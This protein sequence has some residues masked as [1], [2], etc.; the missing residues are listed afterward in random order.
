MPHW[1]IS[2][3][4]AGEPVEWGGR[5]LMPFAY[6]LGVRLPLQNW[7]G[8][9]WTWTRPVSVLVREADGQEKVLPVTNITRR[10]TWTL[11]GA[12]AVIV[13]A[14][15]ILNVINRDKWRKLSHG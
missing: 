14:A 11:Y 1:W 8:A 15:G 12:C 6:T 2:E 10:V 9:Q 5:M 4:S 7:M 3:T 13:L